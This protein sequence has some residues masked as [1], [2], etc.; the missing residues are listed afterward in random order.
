MK[1][2][3]LSASRGIVCCV[4]SLAVFVLVAPLVIMLA[5]ARTVSAPTTDKDGRYFL[6]Q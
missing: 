2:A 4:M 1:P 5:G 6:T 3:A